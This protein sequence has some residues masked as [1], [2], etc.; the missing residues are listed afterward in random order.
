MKKILITGASGFL[1]RRAATFLAQSFS[2]DAPT[3]SQLDLTGPDVE[4]Y[5]L[6]S[7]PDAVIH[8]AALSDVGQCEREPAL[9]RQLNRDASVRIARACR[10]LGT[11]CVLCSSD[12]VYF[13]SALPGPHREDEPLD[14]ANEYGTQKLEAERLCL[15]QNP[16]CVLL[17]LTWMYDSVSASP[18]EHGDFMRSL[19]AQLEAEEPLIY[20]IHDRRGITDVNHVV[21]NLP[22]ALQLPGGVYNFGST[23]R[24]DTFTMM[25]HIFAKLGADP[26]RIHANAQAFRAAPRDLCMDT[27]KAACYGIHFP[28]TEEGIA[29]QLLAH[30]S[31]L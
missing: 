15:Q 9:C 30:R 14:P 25:R 2:I 27:G 28:S 10:T 23:N 4:Q 17:R 20:P 19:L 13:G 18:G 31:L 11:K 12:Q 26:A 6:D 3:H 29:Q 5:L 24:S 7:A 16:N 8:C 21:H 1:G 22:A